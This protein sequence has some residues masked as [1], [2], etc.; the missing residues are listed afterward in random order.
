MRCGVFKLVPFRVPRAP[1]ESGVVLIKRL[2][3]HVETTDS[4]KM[5]SAE[6]RFQ[7]TVYFK[8][9]MTHD[10]VRLAAAA[11]KADYP[12]RGRSLTTASTRWR[13]FVPPSLLS[14][15]GTDALGGISPGILYQYEYH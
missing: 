11:F 5:E 10:Q 12:S 14:M 15:Q 3:K 2:L 6:Q 9:G 4:L 8:G 1:L 7:T 13:R